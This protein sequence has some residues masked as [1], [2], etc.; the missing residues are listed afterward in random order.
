MYHFFFL[1]DSV[2]IKDM[3]RI[4]ERLLESK[5]ALGAYGDLSKLPSFKD[6]EKAFS[7]DGKLPS[8]SRFFLFR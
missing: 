8:A 5:A 7:N 1:S 3:Q 2:T 6:V 4:S